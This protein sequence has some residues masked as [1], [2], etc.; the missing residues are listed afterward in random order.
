MTT[1]VTF[2]RRRG[3]AK[4]GNARIAIYNVTSQNTRGNYKR[5]P[6]VL[7]LTPL[8]HV[9]EWGGEGK[10]LQFK[11]VV[12]Y[13]LFGVDAGE[14]KGLVGGTCWVG[15]GSIKTPPTKNFAALF[16]WIKHTLSTHLP[17]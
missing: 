1:S 14:E 3:L 13:D 4:E 9:S 6:Y 10:T 8:G 7:V 15:G 5:E 17:D 16:T 2:G 12:V 11:E